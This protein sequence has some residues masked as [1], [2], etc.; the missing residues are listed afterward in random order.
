MKSKAYK[1]TMATFSHQTKNGP[2]DEEY[3][4][5]LLANVIVASDGA[6]FSALPHFAAG[7]IPGD[8]IFTVW[9]YLI[10]L[11]ARKRRS[12]IRSQ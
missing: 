8:G 3:L 12:S 6:T 9:S 5:G 4:H 1:L 11:D 10:G 2:M 7:I